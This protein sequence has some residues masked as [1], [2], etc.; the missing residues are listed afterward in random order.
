M[1]VRESLYVQQTMKNS[2]KIIRRLTKWQSKTW[3]FRHFC[4]CLILKHFKLIVICLNK[5]ITSCKRIIKKIIGI[6][7][8]WRGSGY[9]QTVLGMER[10]LF[11]DINFLVF[12]LVNKFLVV[13]IFCLSRFTFYGLMNVNFVSLRCLTILT[14]PW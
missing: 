14:Y 1:A 4:N 9:P 2:V 11:L 13:I 7:A 10:N 3:I 8:N 6:M 5:R 12:F